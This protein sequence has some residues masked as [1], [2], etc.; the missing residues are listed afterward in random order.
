MKKLIPRERVQ[1]VIA[2]MGVVN[3]I[4]TCEQKIE[5]LICQEV[6]QEVM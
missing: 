2:S 3:I 4:L 6:F 1:K 5:M